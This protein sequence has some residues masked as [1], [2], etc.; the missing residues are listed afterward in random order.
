MRT[1]ICATFG[2]QV[3]LRFPLLP[4]AH[5]VSDGEAALRTLMPLAAQG[6]HTD[7]AKYNVKKSF[8]VFCDSR[9]T[10][11]LTGITLAAPAR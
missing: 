7:A 11:S 8:D 6:W 5:G 4:F 3:A 9:I 2:C 1:T 10:E